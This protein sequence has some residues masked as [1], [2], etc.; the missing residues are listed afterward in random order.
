MDARVTEII[1]QGSQLFDDRR[2]LLALWQELADNFYPQRAD[3]TASRSPGT[4]FA[5]HLMTSY[6]VMCHRDL[7]AAISNTRPVGAEWFKVGVKDDRLKEDGDVQAWCAYATG[8][9]QRAMYDPVAKFTRATKE[10]DKDFAGFGQCAI[11]VEMNFR[12]QALLYRTWHLR[13]VVWREGPEG[14]I[15]SVHRDWRPTARNLVKEF[16]PA[17]MAAPVLELLEREP[18]R[19]VACRHVVLPSEDWEW[20][21]KPRNLRRFPYVCLYIDVQNQHVIEETPL[22]TFPWVIPRWETVSGS[23]Y[24]FSPAAI[25]SLPDARLLQAQMLVILESGQKAVDPPLIAKQELFRSDVNLFAGGLTWADIEGDARLS[26]LLMPLHGDRGGQVSGV[27]LATKVEELLASAWFLNKIF[28][29]PFDPG[30]KMT[31]FEVSKRTEEAY[32]AAV[33][34]FEPI[35][36]EYNARLCAA[37]FETLLAQGA[38]D[39]GSMPE[40]LSRR[41]VEFTFESPLRQARGRADIARFQEAAQ[42]TAVGAQLDPALADNFD[43]EAAYR[44]AVRGIGAAPGW[45]RDPRQVG[46]LRALRQKQQQLAQAAALVNAGAQVAGNVGDAATK[47]RDGLGPAQ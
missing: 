24:A 38:F 18:H 10:G 37:T 32:R 14:E 44:D 30:E 2:P 16:G 23:Q 36:A 43:A 9:Q 21:R 39:V 5:A 27:E 40:A 4:E 29:P 6:P 7:A 34:L 35:E 20:R 19:E 46:A 33:T 47:L 41:D 13:D 45:L 28:L 25:V 42:L 15:D 1:R 17:R 26:D 12:A 8:V 22:A 3:F 31:A 11:T